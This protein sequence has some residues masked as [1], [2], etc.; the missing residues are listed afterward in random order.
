MA[1]GTAPI[2]VTD[3]API[4]FDPSIVAA[5]LIGLL[6][7][8]VPLI[9]PL[10][11]DVAYLIGK[12]WPGSW[13]SRA[14]GSLTGRPPQSYQ[15]FSVL[16]VMAIG[17][18]AMLVTVAVVGAAGLAGA[19]TLPRAMLL[20]GLAIPILLLTAFDL[21]YRVLPDMLTLPVAAAGLMAAALVPQAG[22]PEFWIA[23]LGCFGAG[24]LMWL[25]QNG[26]RLL[27]GI[28]GLGGGD[29]KL[30]AAMGAWLGPADC[31]FAIATAAVAALVVEVGVSLAKDGRID[32]TRR[33]PFGAYLCAAFWFAMYAGGFG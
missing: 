12:A 8:T 24:A 15:R 19:M 9:F 30:I 6:L 29:V 18:V 23:T 1:I 32:P 27:R 5:P 22:G 11:A 26:F 17:A 2:R 7:A 3:A 28:D 10:R 25:V 13:L 31:A 33:I 14:V 20:G 21:R 16:D 4:F